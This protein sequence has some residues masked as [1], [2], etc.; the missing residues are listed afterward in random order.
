MNTNLNNLL[1]DFTNSSTMIELQTQ[2]LDRALTISE[3]SYNRSRQF[4]LYLQSLA[5]FSFEYWIH[6][7]EPNLAINIANSSVFKPEVAN[8]IDVICD[9]QVGDFKVCLIPTISNDD[10]EIIIPRYVVDTPEFAAHFYVIV[11]I[12][13][14]LELSFIRGFI[15][16]D[17]LI[18][19]KPNYPL[20]IDWN[21]AVPASLFEVKTEKLLVNLQCLDPQGI[22]LPTIDSNQDNILAEYQTKLPQ[23]LPEV[24]TQPLWKKLTWEEAVTTVT[25]PDLRNWVYQSIN[26]NNPDFN[27]H[28]K[29]LFKLLT[30]QA[31][32]LREWIQTQINELEQE[33]T[34]QMLPAP[35]MSASF[36]DISTDNPAARLDNILAQIS[37]VTN[38]NIP[39]NAGRAYQEFA[40]TTPLRLYAVTWLISETE[41]T[42]SLLLILGGNPNNIPPYGVKLRISDRHAILQEQE[43]TSD[44][45]VAYLC[46]KLEA[47]EEEKLLVT[48]IPPNGS[49]EISRLFEFSF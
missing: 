26:N 11:E 4:N 31:I 13:E 10:S 48:I 37:N 38:I 28:L 34:W 33:L 21:Y 12:D 42:W 40:D 36:R 19:N 14:E 30:Q 32:N 8:I 9:L 39:S 6:A 15:N 46:T 45:G 24:K 7:R 18:D 2:W 22:T 3:N 44:L 20:D 41:K 1:A 25:N 43:L 35:A 29:D 49:P 47:T 17:R 5:L 16:R 23:I 27:L